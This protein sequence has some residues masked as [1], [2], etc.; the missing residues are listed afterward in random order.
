[1]VLGDMVCGFQE[2]GCE[3]DFVGLGLS[4]LPGS[5]LGFARWTP[6]IPEN[7]ADRSGKPMSILA[8]PE[9]W[10]G[11]PCILEGQAP[12]VV[13]SGDSAEVGN[14][15]RAF[16]AT[17]ANRAPL[18]IEDSS[19]QRPPFVAVLTAPA[20]LRATRQVLLGQQL[21][22]LVS[23][24]ASGQMEHLENSRLIPA[25]RAGWCGSKGLKRGFPAMALGAFPFQVTMT[26]LVGWG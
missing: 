9:I 23:C 22:L 1:M 14:V 12:P 19:E 17:V 4:F 20:H 7:F 11:P 16:P 25:N 13:H 18:P 24:G 3:A 15:H 8:F 21:P 6:L 10:F 2:T 26:G 5:G